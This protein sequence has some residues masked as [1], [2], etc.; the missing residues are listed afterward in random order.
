VDNFLL[1]LQKK[2]NLQEAQTKDLLT[3]LKIFQELNPYNQILIRVNA[4]WFTAANP[5]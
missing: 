3:Y 4:E 5:D 2:Y 1:L